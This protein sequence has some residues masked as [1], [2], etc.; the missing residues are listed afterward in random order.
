MKSEILSFQISPDLLA[1]ARIAAEN[2]GVELHQLI[3]SALAE[4]V[5]SLRPE[6]FFRER[7]RNADLPR[8]LEI[9]RDTGRG[10]APAPEDV[11]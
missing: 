8:A 4:K 1:E 5:I 3:R 6:S 7:A 11:L 10:Q 9:L 2:E